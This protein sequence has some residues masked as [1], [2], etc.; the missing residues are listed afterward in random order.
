M[1]FGTDDWYVKCDENGRFLQDSI[2]NPN[3]HF[4]VTLIKH[5]A[6]DIDILKEDC[7]CLP[8]EE[9]KI[10]LVRFVRRFDKNTK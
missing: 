10:R 2:Q 4:T 7:L 5:C 9:L 1:N 6:V 8:A 3:T